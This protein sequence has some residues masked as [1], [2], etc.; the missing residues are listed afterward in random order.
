MESEISIAGVRGDADCAVVDEAA[1][2]VHDGH[3]LARETFRGVVWLDRRDRSSHVCHHAGEVDARLACV[4]AEACGV[5]GVLC[6]VGGGD[7]AL[8]GDAA[9]P[10]AIAAGARLLDEACPRADRGGAQGGD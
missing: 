10:E 9:C 8:G 7:Q 1:V 5:A 2:A 4:D 6:S 3:A